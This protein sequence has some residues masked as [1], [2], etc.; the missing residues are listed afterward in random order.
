M[1]GG[2]AGAVNIETRKPLEFRKPFTAELSAQAIYADLAR[3]TDPQLNGL[4]NWKNEANTAGVLL[5]VFSE[6]RHERRDGQE[7]FGYGAID[8]NSPAAI[9]HPDLANVLAPAG[10]N[11]ALFEQTRKREGGVLDIQVKPT[12]DLTLDLNGFYSKLDAANYNRSFYNQP[13]SNLNAVDANG[14]L[15]GVVPT[16]YLVKNNTLVSAVFS[17]SGFQAPVTKAQVTADPTLAPNGQ[18]FPGVVD[19][20]YRPGSGAESY[21]VDFN[22]SYRAS[23]RLRFSGSA[24]YTHGVGKTPL[25]IGYEAGLLNT[26]MAYQLNGM[27]PADSSFPGGTTSTFSNVV[28]LAGWGSHVEAI[29]SESYAQADGELT[30]DKGI[31]ESVKFGARFSQHHRA[32]NW[33]ESASCPT[34][35]GTTDAPLPT[36][37]G[38]VYPSNFG[39]G[40]GAGSGFLKNVWQLSPTAVQGWAS[41]YD[42]SG[43]PNTR[44]WAAELDV[45]EKDTAVYAMANLAGDNWRGNFGAR[46]VNTHQ[47]TI[48]NVPGGPN[49]VG[50]GNVNGVYTPTTDV[51]DYTDVLPSANIKFDLNK[52]LVARLAI[53]RTMARADY[54]AL[55]GAVSLDD[56]TLTGNGGNPNLKPIRSTNLDATLEWYFAPKSAVSLGL[57]YMD[58]S[59]YVTFGVAPVVYYNNTFKKFNTYQIVS[60]TNIAAKNKGFELGYQQALGGGFGLLA[61]YTYTD[62]KAAD[63]SDVVGNSKQTYNAE[64]YYENDRFSARLAYTYRSSYLVGLDR[65]FAQHMDAEGN[66]AA[67]LNYKINSTFTLTFDALNLNNPV[68]KYYGENRDQPRALYSNGRQYYFGVRMEL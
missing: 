38:A 41:V 17:P 52:N 25:D 26:G 34:C 56:N 48:T 16:S 43:G 12:S 50:Q 67:S 20:I 9:A 36:W 3:K 22:G 31:W 63:G 44:N 40:F 32:V 30:L 6:K 62:G 59:S 35:D 61:N 8:P 68:L 5:Q 54:S 11:S 4:F 29:D 2:V 55:V 37:N 66:L 46:V 27:S 51:H 28:T 42:T 10:I 1:E 19:Q 39:S 53:A 7:I 21:Y 58:M 33:P 64:G 13:L 45:K 65:S 24:G 57:F 14:N 23:D 60:P 18:L 15:V 47:V 49:P